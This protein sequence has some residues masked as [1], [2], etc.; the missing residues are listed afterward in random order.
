M[1]NYQNFIDE[2]FRLTIHTVR[3][4]VADSQI[5]Y[6]QLPEWYPDD[7]PTNRLPGHI[8][9]F[10]SL[11]QYDQHLK[12]DRY[13]DK[14]VAMQRQAVTDVLL[15]ESTQINRLLTDAKNK[16]ERLTQLLKNAMKY[17]KAWDYE[18]LD[19]LPAAFLELQLLDVFTIKSR[20][21]ASP[22]KRFA[23]HLTDA[24]MYK[25]GTLSGFIKQV[26]TDLGINPVVLSDNTREPEYDLWYV[27]NDDAYASAKLKELVRYLPTIEPFEKRAEWFF[28]TSRIWEIETSSMGIGSRMVPNPEHYS[29]IDEEGK[30][31]DKNGQSVEVVA[32]GIKYGN[33]EEKGIIHKMYFLWFYR[34]HRPYYLN[35]P[36]FDVEQLI[37]QYG[38][39]RQ[40]ER[41]KRLQL[42]WVMGQISDRQRII[43]DWL[44]ANSERYGKPEIRRQLQ[45]AAILIEQELERVPAIKWNLFYRTLHLDPFALLWGLVEYKRFL[46]TEEVAIHSS[47]ILPI[48]Q[49]EK[50]GFNDMAL[51]EVEQWFVQLTTAKSK[52][53][54]P[55]LTIQQLHTFIS[56]A[57]GGQ[58]FSE[59]LSLNTK[60][61]D[62]ANVVGL[63]HLFYTHCITHQP[64][65]G[66]IDPN[67][68]AEK[69]I[70]LLTDHF[71]NWTFEQVKPNFRSGGAWNNKL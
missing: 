32:W 5:L 63:F 20:P 10:M 27:N 23:H 40:T 52:N 39:Q 6:D 71:D 24:I 54:S 12:E 55:F 59:K 50:S 34:T 49:V 47:S 45:N 25:R 28:E 11:E 67:A 46:E 33:D 58:V 57:F 53:G 42:E 18:A 48:G 7:T 60:A 43:N 3:Y 51:L 66:R 35:K 17:Q 21:E 70:R 30:Q 64:G 1:Q 26:E 4:F 68:T 22:H 19:S 9:L 69:Y 61:G 16:C 56:R 13:A 14:L 31:V 62:K 44:T 29:H 2:L 41:G 38:T 15:L 36:R 37:N 65:K 8:S